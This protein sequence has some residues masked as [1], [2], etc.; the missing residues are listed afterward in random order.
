M[1]QNRFALSDCLRKSG[2]MSKVSDAQIELSE[3]S[4][5]D[6]CPLCHAGTVE[7]V[8]GEVRCRGECGSV[9]ASRALYDYDIAF[10]SA[11]AGF[12]GRRKSDRR[13]PY[14]VFA[15]R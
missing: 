7:L 12:S 8:N 1:G 15:S 5:G 2:S 11:L 3:A 4:H 10:R 6:E 9:T 13:Y 14:G